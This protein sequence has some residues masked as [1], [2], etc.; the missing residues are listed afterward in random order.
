VLVLPARS[1]VRSGNRCR[2][3]GT[4][5]PGAFPRKRGRASARRGRFRGVGYLLRS[6]SS[7]PWRI[8]SDRWM[9]LGKVRDQ[10]RQMEGF[11]PRHWR[12]RGDV[13]PTSS[14]TTSPTTI[15]AATTSPAARAASCPGSGAPAPRPPCEPARR[16]GGGHDRLTTRQR[17]QRLAARRSHHGDLA[18]D[19][20]RATRPTTTTPPT[21]SPRERRRLG[22][23][24]RGAGKPPRSGTHRAPAVPSGPGNPG[25]RISAS[26]PASTRSTTRASGMT[27]HGQPSCAPGFATTGPRTPPGWILGQVGWG[28]RSSIGRM[29]LGSPFSRT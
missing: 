12:F 15:S 23:R 29:G 16:G 21:I 20:G 1:R 10:G 18:D 22:E 11:A 28:T 5:R 26:H 8:A 13:D 4:R 3:V 9:K 14:E 17:P 19:D 7:E 2:H 6:P 25:R 24:F 27:R